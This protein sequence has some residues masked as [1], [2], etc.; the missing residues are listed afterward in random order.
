MDPFMEAALEEA[1]RG[2]REG[3]I[4]IGAVLV[5]QGKIIGRGHNQ[6]VQQADPIL[7]A[8]IDCLRS[9]GRIGTY[10]ETTLYSTLMPCY[11]CSGAVVQFGIRQVVAGESESLQGGAE[12]M[13]AHGVQVLNLDLD[14]CKELMRQF[15]RQNPQ[16]WLEDIGQV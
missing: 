15:I 12:L 7:H 5:R 14:E 10:R 9:A 4:P 8:E 6:R 2:L 13:E 3:G 11:L 16:L 1:R